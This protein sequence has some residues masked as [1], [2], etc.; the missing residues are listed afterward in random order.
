MQMTSLNNQPIIIKAI[1]IKVNMYVK[2]AGNAITI[3]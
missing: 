2:R 1:L 3:K